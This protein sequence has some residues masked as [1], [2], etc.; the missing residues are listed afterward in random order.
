MDLCKFQF[1]FPESRQTRKILE[2]TKMVYCP[3][4]P[5]ASGFTSSKTFSLY[6]RDPCEDIIYGQPSLHE[7]PIKSLKISKTAVLEY[8]LKISWLQIFIDT[9]IASLSLPL[10]GKVTKNIS[11]SEVNSNKQCKFDRNQQSSST[12]SHK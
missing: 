12:I 10:S 4:E 6:W 8:L 5:L 2:V 1:M 3:H 11:F 7:M 9:K